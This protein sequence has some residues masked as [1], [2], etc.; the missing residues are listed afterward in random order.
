MP[1]LT[2]I[3]E[4]DVFPASHQPLRAAIAQQGGKIL[5]WQDNWLTD[6]GLPALTDGPVVFHGSL[7]NAATI[8][9]ASPWRPGAYCATQKF[10]CSAWYEGARKWLIHRKWEILPADEFV[11]HP[12]SIFSAIGASERVFVRPDSPLKP[13]SGRVLARDRVTLAALDYGFYHD[14][15][16]IPVV[17]APVCEISREWRF[18]VVRNAV[19]AGSAYEPQARRAIVELP[20][21]DAWAFASRVAKE[22]SP[23]EEV[24][25]MD[26][27]EI[28]GTLH[29]LELNP[30][31]GADLYASS[32]CDIVAALTA[33]AQDAWNSRRA[34]E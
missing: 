32:A 17:V 8:A 31:S 29:L 21:T 10:Y 24:Y 3:L 7:G 34:D 19:V 25:V 33:V 2:W 30:F 28:S 23:P 16:T 12:D 26:L 14:D 1:A 27:C 13:F 11:K 18:F 22:L 20:A 6:G 4:S 15:S 5:D 9:S